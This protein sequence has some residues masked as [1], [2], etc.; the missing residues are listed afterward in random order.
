MAIRGARAFTGRELI[1]K[2]DGAYHGHSDL[3][4]VKAGSGAAT[5][6]NPDSA[7]VPARAV[8]T[9]ATLAFNDFAALDAC[10]APAYT[11]PRQVIS[12]STNPAAKTVA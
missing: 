7:G 11:S 3:L 4:L 2:F 5:F 6:G 12:N 1:V 10:G 9:T 8:E